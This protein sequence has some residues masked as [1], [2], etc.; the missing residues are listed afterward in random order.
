MKTPVS[1]LP[2]SSETK[3][4]PQSGARLTVN[5]EGGVSVPAKRKPIGKRLRF[6]I[7]ARDGFT[8]R[9]C[10]SQADT[11]TLEV[12]H[13]TPVCQGGTNEPENLITACK[14][15]NAGKSGKTIEQHTP[16]ET[17]RLRLSQERNEQIESLH[18]AKRAAEARRAIR[19]EVAAYF[20][21]A[22]GVRQM[23]EAQL[24][25]L[26]CYLEEVGPETLFSWIDKAAYVVDS[27]DEV[28]ACRY[29]SGIRRNIREGQNNA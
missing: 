9:Y 12:D 23:K 28:N 1:H 2:P 29:I 20:C 21:G 4:L 22:V 19:D 11:T 24:R 5:G 27:G 10:G 15:C 26:L 7:F 16:T 14:A 25:T 3:L 13:I 8:C 18:A 6:E 17:D